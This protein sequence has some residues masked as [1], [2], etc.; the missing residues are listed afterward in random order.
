MINL[1][2]GPNPVGLEETFQSY[3][4]ER[5]I[6]SYQDFGTTTWLAETLLSL[7]DVDNVEVHQ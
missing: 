5:F 4:V 7:I 6:I 1:V 3:Q 2:N